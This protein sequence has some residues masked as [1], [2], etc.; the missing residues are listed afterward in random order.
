MVYFLS[1]SR[2]RER[3]F[4]TITSLKTGRFYSVFMALL[5]AVASHQVSASLVVDF[6]GNYVDTVAGVNRVLR[7]G[8]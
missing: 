7:G 1:V 4:I 5:L 8:I 6:G 3:K 2:D